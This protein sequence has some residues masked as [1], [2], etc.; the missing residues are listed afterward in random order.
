M[1]QLDVT[2]RKGS[3]T[4]SLDFRPAEEPG[5]YSADILP[6]KVG[7]YEVLFR[8]SIAGQA[9][10][11]QVEIESVE[12]TLLVE[13]PPRTDTDPS[14]LP[15]DIIE[16]LQQVIADLT[17]QVDQATS[18]SEE[19]VESATEATQAAEELKMSADRS[20]IF[21]MVGVGVGVAGIV[22]GVVAL[23]RSKE[24]I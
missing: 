24:K 11:S 22:I 10:N 8:G 23:T 6:T 17:A 4:K 18:A 16:Q 1:S 21:G 5:T 12:D 13:F 14:P 19:A 2:I 3:V 20:Y 9:I 7:Q 15:E